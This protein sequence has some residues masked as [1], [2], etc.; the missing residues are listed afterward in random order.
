MIGHNYIE[1]ILSRSDKIVILIEEIKNT[2]QVYL[3]H[4]CP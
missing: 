2:T 4:I 3:I 1:R